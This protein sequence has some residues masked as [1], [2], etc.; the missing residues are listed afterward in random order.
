MAVFANKKKLSK[1]GYV[2]LQKKT[3][4]EDFPF[5]LSDQ[6]LTVIE[7]MN[8]KEFKWL[9]RCASKHWYSNVECV[10]CHH[11]CSGIIALRRNGIPNHHRIINQ[12]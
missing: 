4:D 12:K 10:I 8:K 5:N 6:D 2:I 11:L 7:Q 1:D 3:E 9:L